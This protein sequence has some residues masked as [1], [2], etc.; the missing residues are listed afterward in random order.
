[1]NKIKL[2]LLLALLCSP[3][4]A[5]GAGT[6][7]A[8]QPSPKAAQ[9]AQE[10]A[11]AVYDA[12]AKLLNEYYAGPKMGQVAALTKQGRQQLAK[13]CAG[14][15]PCPVSKGIAATRTLLEGRLG[16]RHGGVV[17]PFDRLD[18]NDLPA[19]S[20]STFGLLATPLKP[21]LLAVQYVK[22]ESAA[23]RAGIAVGDVVVLTPPQAQDKAFDLWQ[24]PAADSRVTLRVRRAGEERTVTLGA[25]PGSAV[26]YATLRWQGKDAVLA[27]P[28][29]TP[30]TSQV[31][32]EKL[33]EVCQ[34]KANN[35]I[36]DLR[37]HGGGF[38]DELAF[39]GKALGVKN[40]RLVDID[41]QGR[42]YELDYAAE[43]PAPP[44]NCWNRLAVLVGP[45]TTSAGEVLAYWLQREG[46][47]VYGTK[48][49]G[50]LGGALAYFKI[51]GP[52]RLAFTVVRSTLDGKTP[53]PDF[54]TP[55]IPT[56][57]RIQPQG[58]DPLNEL[59]LSGQWQ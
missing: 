54:V 3:A 58:T 52:A 38:S 51:P 24:A 48:T 28:L 17:W 35:L 19:G 29:L 8:P 47:T 12:A 27:L 32:D 33:A 39:V 21:G 18:A 57:L 23:D 55:D 41:R 49:F 36:V 46:H 5:Q 59:L 53:L 25:Q 34:K 26:P 42:R 1:M 15:K 2:G 16:D 50:V 20:I 11:F 30:T 31:V 4:A 22:P 45:E 10:D 6:R 43:R 13:A 40:P 9:A 7:S 44:R 14:L 56:D 37:F